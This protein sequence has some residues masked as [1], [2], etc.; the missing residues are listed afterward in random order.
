[1]HVVKIAEVRFTAADRVRDV[2]QRINDD[3]FANNSTD[4]MDD[5]QVRD[6]RAW[7]PP[8][9]SC[10]RRPQPGCAARGASPAGTP[11]HSLACSR[12]ERSRNRM[13]S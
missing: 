4:G 3:R 9:P 1:M 13:C 5:H 8:V 6:Y 2:I 11:A 7:P 12:P 10:R